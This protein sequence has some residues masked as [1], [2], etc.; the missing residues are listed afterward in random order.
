MNPSDLKEAD[1]SIFQLLD[2]VYK[3]PAI[4]L[5][6]E[7]SL[8]RLRS[9]LVGYEC[10]LARANLFLRQSEIF[11]GFNDWIAEELEFP[12]STSGWCNMV[13]ERAGSD[14][15][16]YELFFKLLGKFR[17]ARGIGNDA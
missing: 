8:K 5:D 6:G 17:Q 12:E 9:F 10:G 13:Q 15:S 3:K 14:K 1:H 2:W 4:F 11:A 7:G 16:A